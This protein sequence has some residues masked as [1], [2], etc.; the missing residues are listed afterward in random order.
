MMRALKSFYLDFIHIGVDDATPPHMV[1]TVIFS[2]FL[3][4]LVTAL[5]GV[6]ALSNFA[7]GFRFLVLI[8]AWYQLAT[9]ACF[10]LNSR[11]RYLAARLTLL[12]AV[13]AGLFFTSAIQGNVVQLEHF[14]LPFAITAFSLF[15]PSERRYSL[16]FVVLSAAAFLFFVDRAA[17]LWDVDPA[18]GRYTLHELHVNQM[19]CA[20]YFIFSLVGLSDGY[21]RAVRILD[22]QRAQVF[23]Q[24]RLSA[25]GAMAAS[26]AHEINS[27][28]A[29]MDA[30]LHL[31]EAD[32][33]S[34]AGADD[35][36]AVESMRKLSRRI[37]AVVRGFKLL[38]RSESGSAPAKVALKELV[39]PVLDIGEGRLR[40]A[41]ITL[42]TALHDPELSVVCR[43]VETS[44]IVLNLLNNAI[45]AAVER[46][47][48]DRWIRLD[49]GVRG[50]FLWIAVTDSGRIES[51]TVKQSLFTP[52]FTTKAVGKGTGIGLSVSQDAARAQGGG[53]HFD[54]AH[55]NTRFV[56]ELPLSQ[57]VARR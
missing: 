27:P 4:L 31:L 41:G 16:L 14:F 13:F 15:H 43:A 26:I 28:L 36:L 7:T 34:P 20:V 22:R 19:S 39:Q 25:I 21:W 42:T 40:P 50:G 32:F 47:A 46:D 8:N 17:P 9:L 37:A 11:H 24:N 35:R 2:N 44:Q 23:E 1:D 55:P 5:N 51:P 3:C 48:A 18:R 53:L 54:A 10:F 29:A 52:F 57:D 12:G 56:L 49:S 33:D 38:A 30:H 6:V 45:D